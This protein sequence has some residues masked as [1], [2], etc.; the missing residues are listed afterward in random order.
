MHL[1]NGPMLTCNRGRNWLPDNKDSQLSRLCVNESNVAIRLSITPT[2]MLHTKTLVK[3]QI[4]FDAAPSRLTWF[5]Y[6]QDAAMDFSTFI[7]RA[8]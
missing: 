8:K 3:I 5:V 2:G 4:T 1:H 7:F 6:W